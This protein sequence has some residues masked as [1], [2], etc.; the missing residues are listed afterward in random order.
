MAFSRAA[1]A[2][3]S[4][5]PGRLRRL[6]YLAGA[7]VA[8]LTFSHGTAASFTLAEAEPSDDIDT[9]IVGGTPTDNTAV[10][11]HAAVIT[12]RPTGTFICGGS[13]LSERWIVTAAHCLDRATAVFV[14]TGVSTLPTAARESQPARRIVIHPGFT[15]STF[16]NDIALIELSTPVFLDGVTRREINLPGLLAPTWP[17]AG[18]AARI[19]GW[20]T[21]QAYP[22][23][24]PN[25]GRISDQLRQATALVLGSP[26]DPNCGNYGSGF[27]A[28]MMLCAGAPAGGIDACQGDSGGPLAVPIGPSWFLAGIVSF[29]SGCGTAGYPGVYTRVTTYLSWIAQTTGIVTCSCTGLQPVSPK[30]LLDTRGG[31]RPMANSVTAITINGQ[32]GIPRNAVAALLNVTAINPT[33]TGYLTVFPCGTTPPNASNVNYT[34]GQTIP[35][36]AFSRIGTNNQV[37]VFTNVA[38]DIIVDITGYSPPV[39]TAVKPTEPTRLLDTR[40]TARPAANSVTPITIPV[41]AAAAMLN[42]TAT[43]PTASGYLTVYPCG[44]DP[45]NASNLNYT[46]GQTIPNAAFS[47]IGTNGQVCVFT[48]VAT[49]IIVDM[50]GFSPPAPD[51]MQAITPSRLLD[52]RTTS[53]PQARSI[54]RITIDSR[55]GVPRTAGAVMLNVTATGASSPGYLT[56]YPC[57]SAPPNASNLNYTAGQTIANTAY[58]QVGTDNQVCIFSSAATNIVVDITGYSFAS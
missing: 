38:T 53:R 21:T 52:T 34:A 17:E 36:T 35:N 24:S 11:W 49:D 37:C 47:R 5:P 32:P 51:A 26:D 18:T 3:R 48:N 45:P 27:R 22:P 2:P 14:A 19:S 12:E 9:A 46:A 8:A 58:T 39:P 54:T 28:D 31:N 29:G 42:I 40:T 16:A 4:T 23:N 1:P 43:R 33:A 44:V 10:P 7:M 41:D 13:I 30:R 50:T 56:I 25:P 20:G 55:G 6:R 15:R 57:G